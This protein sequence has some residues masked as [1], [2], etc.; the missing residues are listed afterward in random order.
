MFYWAIVFLIVAII[1]AI[2]GFTGIAGA[3]AWMA[4]V[5]FVIGLILFSGVSG[6]RPP[7]ASLVVTTEWD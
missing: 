5:L 4:K 2:L 1:A 6:P 3:A 7:A